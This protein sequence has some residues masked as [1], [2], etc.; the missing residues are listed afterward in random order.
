MANKLP[1]TPGIPSLGSY[2]DVRGLGT[3]LVSLQRA[4]LQNFS[5]I[6]KVVNTAI[7]TDGSSEMLR[8]LVGAEYLKAALPAAATWK[9][10]FVNVTDEAG[11]YTMAFSDG[12]NWRRVQDRAIVS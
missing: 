2:R 4:L 8:P 6:A 9:G 11:G 5:E 3:Y 10:G 7:F 12:T 1:S